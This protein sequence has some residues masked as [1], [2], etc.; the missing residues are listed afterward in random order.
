MSTHK[1]MDETTPI[2]VTGEKTPIDLIDETF[3]DDLQEKLNARQTEEMRR[4]R[5]SFHVVSKVLSTNHQNRRKSKAIRKLTPDQLEDLFKNCIKLSSENKINAKN[6]WNL[7]LI[8]YIDEV[9]EN[10]IEEKKFQLASCTLDASMKIYSSRVDSVFSETFKVLGGLNRAEE[11]KPQD[12]EEEEEQET[13][14]KEKKEKKKKVKVGV[15]TLET[16]VSNLNMKKFEMEHQIQPLCYQSL[17][18]FDVGSA[19]SLLLNNLIISEKVEI[20]LDQESY[21][22]FGDKKE[23]KQDDIQIESEL[24]GREENKDIQQ[25]QMEIEDKPLNVPLEDIQHEKETQSKEDLQEI[26]QPT[27]YD[28]EFGNDEEEDVIQVPQEPQEEKETEKKS[29][30]MVEHLLVQQTEGESLLDFRNEYSY[31]NIDQKLNKKNWSGLTHWKVTKKPNEKK[32]TEKTIKEI[33]DFEDFEIDEKDFEIC[34]D[35]DENTVSNTTIQKNSILNHL[36]PDDIHYKIEELMKTFHISRNIQFIQRKK[37]EGSKDQEDFGTESFGV[38]V[39][40][41]IVEEEPKEIVIDHLDQGKSVELVELPKQIEKMKIDFAKISSKVDV[42]AL[43]ENIW[44]DLKDEKEKD[45]S[46]LVSDLNAQDENVSIPF[47]FICLL[48][49]AN[50]RGLEITG[51]EDLSDLQI[52]VPN[53]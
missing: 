12:E 40:Q 2:D 30:N 48:H 32:K 11:R 51:R 38:D 47:T 15:R 33:I 10:N 46:G 45:F 4:K 53:V 17:K 16:N 31:V 8:D 6:T 9:I 49:I 44:N 1:K 7:N 22:L 35:L 27:L 13:N 36:L 34:E 18:D 5:S 43:K 29:N 25:E 23:E 21:F 41:T 19:K 39:P 26:V 50:E 3:N 28:Q 37:K 14:E 20:V 52:K 42:K 24:L